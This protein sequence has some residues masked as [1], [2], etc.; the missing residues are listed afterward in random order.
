[1][2]ITLEKMAENRPFFRADTNVPMHQF[3]PELRR[4]DLEGIH[5]L[6]FRFSW[7]LKKFVESICLFLNRVRPW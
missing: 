3:K 5:L 6:S 1:M 2:E 7:K 4:Q